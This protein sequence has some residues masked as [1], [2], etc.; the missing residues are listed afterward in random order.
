LALLVAE[1][2]RRTGLTRTQAMLLWLGSQPD[3][4]EP[5]PWQA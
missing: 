1:V 2:Q 3:G 5:D 4:G